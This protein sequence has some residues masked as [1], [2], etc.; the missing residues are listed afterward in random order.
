[1]VFSSDGNGDLHDPERHDIAWE[2]QVSVDDWLTDLR[3]H[4]HVIALRPV[5]R[6]AFMADIGAVLR[7]RFGETMVVPYQTRVWLARRR[8]SAIRS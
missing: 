4:S 6:E 8:G 3:S 5:A 1:V 2:R 7:D